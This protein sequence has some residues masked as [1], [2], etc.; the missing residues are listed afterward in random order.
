MLVSAI[1][2]NPIHRSADRLMLRSLCPRTDR[3]TLYALY[4]LVPRGGF[5]IFD[6][7]RQT[8]PSVAIR[9]FLREQALPDELVNVDKLSNFLQ[10][11]TSN[12]V[13]WSKK[14]AKR[15]RFGG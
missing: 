13:D 9:D 12:K 7:G 1:S 15:F 3:D 6:D 5:I 10:K 4:D 8:E 11:K 14:V 2:S